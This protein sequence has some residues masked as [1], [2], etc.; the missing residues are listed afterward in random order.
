MGREARCRCRF[1][2]GEGEVKALLETHELILRGDLRRKF[3][4]GA[5]AD[6]RA[7]GED[8]LFTAAADHIALALGASVAARWAKAIATPPP[9]LTRKLGI[10]PKTRVLVV[11]GIDD[12]ELRTATEAATTNRPAEATFALSQVSDERD[13]DRAVRQHARLA[14]AKA[15][16]WIVYAKGPAS[17]YGETAVRAAMRA[18]GFVDTKVASVSQR[19]T[20]ARYSRRANA[21][22]MV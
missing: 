3:L 18:R 16:L 17:K 10:G 20:A 11:G 22:S 9:T 5:L 15:P 13:L 6:V 2:G 14:D 19:L 7:E 1:D 12:P 8:L 4:I 21:G